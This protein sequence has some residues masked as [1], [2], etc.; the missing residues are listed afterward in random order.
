LKIKGTDYLI[1]EQSKNTEPMIY[2]RPLYHSPTFTEGVIFGLKMISRW[3]IIKFNKYLFRKTE[4][5]HIGWMRK[6]EQYSLRKIKKIYPPKNHFWADPF[7]TTFKN[8]E[9]LFLEEY[10]YTKNKGRIINLKLDKI[11]NQFHGAKSVLETNYHLSFPFTLI[12]NGELYVIPETKSNNTISLYQWINEKLEFKCNLITDIKA[13]D[14]TVLYKDS[15]Y[16]LFTSQQISKYGTIF[17]QCIYYAEKLEGPYIP[18]EMNPISSSSK[19][20]RAAGGILKIANH[21]Y[22]SSQDCSETYGKK[23]SLFKIE[24]LT[25]K[26]Y[27]EVE[28]DSIEAK[29]DKEISKIH[30]FNQSNNIIV[31]DLYGKIKR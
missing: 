1:N 7:I 5:W 28:V 12:D 3:I 19:V 20:S 27:K 16:W 21:F 6:D 29:W 11:T 18:H 2:D 4:D 9:L 23:V 17:H 22:R 13:V 15:K 31:V 26:T 10:E 14:T 30:T 25:T 24:E 8:E